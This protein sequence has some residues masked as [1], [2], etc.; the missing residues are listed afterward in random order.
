MVVLLCLL[1]LVP[2]IALG[3]NQENSNEHDFAYSKYVE[4][5]I[6]EKDGR[7]R[8]TSH[9]KVKQTY[10][11]ERSTEETVH[12]FGEYFYNR[13]KKVKASLRGK[14]IKG[15]NITYRPTQRADVFLSGSKTHSIRLP[16]DIKPGDKFSYEYREEFTDIAFLPIQYIPNYDYLEGY[17][18]KFKHPQELKIDFEFFF[19][20]G[21][22]P[23]EISH[24]D[25]KTT[26]LSFDTLHY[27]EEIPEFEYNNFHAAVLTTIS[28]NDQLITP[29]DEKSFHSWYSRL[30]NLEPCFDTIHQDILAA[31]LDTI[32]DPFAKLAFIND[33]VKT[34]VR[35]IA[36]E[37]AINAIVP[38]HPS[39]VFERKYGDC[40][41]RASLVSAIARQQDL[42]V[43]MTLINV[44]PRPIFKSLHPWLFDHVICAYSDS[45]GT[46]FFD[47]TQRYSDFGIV[48][49]AIM[50]KEAIILDP[51][52]LRLEPIIRTD[53][54]PT[55]ELHI[56]GDIDSI[57]ACEA[58]II[59]R[60][61]LASSARYAHNELTG[62]KLENYLSEL[63][64]SR[65]YKMTIEDFEP[66]SD[67]YNTV[68]FSARADLSDFIISSTSKKYIP[69]T[70]FI[71]AGKDILE[72]RSD[73]LP[74]YAP[75]YLWI[76]FE[77][78]LDLGGF[79]INTDSVS[80]PGANEISYSA[81]V[82]VPESSRVN[83]RYEYKRSKKILRGPAKN[84]FLDFYEWY[85]KNRK[86][87][88][89]LKGVE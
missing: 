71:F 69:Q 8:L 23:Y 5:A 83:F 21:E 31:E 14:K 67:D 81:R 75:G 52:S 10:L 57:K 39:K 70:P 59:L 78:D 64:T 79:E 48:S 41:D 36:D 17:K 16:Q 37:R 66:V 87:M 60:Y 51:D 19:S 47:P 18:I 53:F 86:Q 88:F 77:L 30:T 42:E 7:C 13:V 3:D 62:I 63:I 72:R 89:I 38:H 24:P 61:N 15:R 29:T 49:D 82:T 26:I 80:A 11:S 35:Y 34:N 68:R 40:K 85:L 22:I 27:F 33:Y 6:K 74:I 20:R 65:F 55:I 28:K 12:V 54:L 58:D 73:S 44:N 43:S 1:L 2:S 45:G 9:V 25:E 84:E 46:I 50:E 4:Y 32:S 56:A 76:I